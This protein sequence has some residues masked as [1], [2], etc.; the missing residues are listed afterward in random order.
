MNGS[1]LMRLDSVGIDIYAIHGYFHR[2]TVGQRTPRF[3]GCHCYCYLNSVFFVFSMFKK[4]KTEN[5]MCFSCFL[6]HK[7][8]L[9]DKNQTC[10][11]IP[12]FVANCCMRF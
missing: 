4:K 2:L 7:T 10:S 6:E 12:D 8:T 9:K 11:M 1:Q 5:Q 3:F